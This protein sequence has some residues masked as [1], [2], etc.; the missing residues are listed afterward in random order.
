MMNLSA[1]EA[2]VF[3]SGHCPL[4]LGSTQKPPTQSWIGQCI[5]LTWRREPHCFALLCKLNNKESQ[6]ALAE[7]ARWLKREKPGCKIAIE[8]WTEGAMPLEVDYVLEGES[9]YVEGRQQLSSATTGP[10][11]RVAMSAI[12]VHVIICVGGDGTLLHASSLCENG[13]VPPVMSFNLGTLGFLMPFDIDSFQE[14]MQRLFNSQMHVTLRMRLKCRV[15]RRIQKSNGEDQE[16]EWEVSALNDLVVER[17]GRS[18]PC[19]LTCT[20]QGT[21]LVNLTADGVIV[22]TPTGS[23]AYSLAAGGALVHPQVPALLLTPICPHILSSRPVVL[24]AASE[25]EIMVPLGSRSGAF[26]SFDG[27]RRTE[28]SPGDSILVSMSPHPLPSVCKVN[29]TADWFN[30]LYECLGWA[31]RGRKD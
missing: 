25:I 4:R 3:S 31:D 17:G 10:N 1:D 9:E 19:T 18:M 7:I 26:A 13:P 8:K 6:D 11:S 22:S 23:T 24:P 21:V 27:R 30:S 20:C 2:Y 28:L 15:R 14:E 12:G 29:E 16:E 5:H